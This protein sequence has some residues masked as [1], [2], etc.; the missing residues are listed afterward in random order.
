MKFKIDEDLPAEAADILRE[1]GY[2]AVTV[3]S[4]NLLGSKDELLAD[5]CRSEVSSALS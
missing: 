1:A 2:D 4:Q 5:I 3:L